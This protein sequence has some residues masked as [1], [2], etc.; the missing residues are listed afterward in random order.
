MQFIFVSEQ[1]VRQI[2]VF[3]TAFLFYRE[4]IIFFSKQLM[5]QNSVPHNRI[6]F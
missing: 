4:C 3:L 5:A 1:P 2:T 6:V